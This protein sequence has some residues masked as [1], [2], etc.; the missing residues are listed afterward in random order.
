VN[1]GHRPGPTA[2]DECPL[3]S[4]SLALSDADE[5]APRAASG[6]PHPAAA[7]V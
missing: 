1:L 2:T 3:V 4:L 5:R 7:G 6:L